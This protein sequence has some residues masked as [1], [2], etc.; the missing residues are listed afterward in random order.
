MNNQ[1]TK[2]E[3]HSILIEKLELSQSD[4]GTWPGI[5]PGQFI[6][7]VMLDEVSQS[8]L[9]NSHHQ[10]IVEELRDISS[11]PDSQDFQERHD[12][13]LEI[14]DSFEPVPQEGS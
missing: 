14:L 13:F 4:I 11:L 1:M 8:S 9:T 7:T 12:K 10:A 2:S 5:A 3:Y 6:P